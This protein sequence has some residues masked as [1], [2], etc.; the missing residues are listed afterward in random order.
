MGAQVLD[1]QQFDRRNFLAK[2][3]VVEKNWAKYLDDLSIINHS[4]EPERVIQDNSEVEL[5]FNVMP[6]RPVTEKL[7]IREYRLWDR[8]AEA[9][10]D[11]EYFS[12]M[13]KSPNHLVF[14][15]ACAHFQKICY[16]YLTHEFGFEYGP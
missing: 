5:T 11:R 15:T 16:V 7:K 4:R 2:Q 13:E 6:N 10:L 3:H 14:L 8:Y 9:T 1:L 12:S